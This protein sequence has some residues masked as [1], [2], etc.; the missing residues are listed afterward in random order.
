MPT[1]GHRGAGLTGLAGIA[2]SKGPRIDQDDTTGIGAEGAARTG[3][4]RLQVKVAWDTL[5]SRNDVLGRDAGA[6]CRT[7]A[8]ILVHQPSR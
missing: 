1:D 5:A 4:V 8:L 6:F 2:Q 7:T 3:A